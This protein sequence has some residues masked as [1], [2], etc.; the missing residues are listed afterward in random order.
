MWIYSY[1]IL[2][3]SQFESRGE[4]YLSNIV[5]RHTKVIKVYNVKSDMYMRIHRTEIVERKV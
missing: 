5:Y 2:T 4:S 1:F 3:D